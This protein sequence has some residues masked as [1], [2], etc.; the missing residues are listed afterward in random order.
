MISLD[1]EVDV[2]VYEG[3]GYGNVRLVREDIVFVGMLFFDVIF[4]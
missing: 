3:D 2:G 4:Y 1:E